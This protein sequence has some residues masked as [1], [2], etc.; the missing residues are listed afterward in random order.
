MQPRD[1]DGWVLPL[2]TSPINNVVHTTTNH[3]LICRHHNNGSCHKQIS[4]PIRILVRNIGDMTASC[5]RRRH[6]SPIPSKQV[7]FTNTRVGADTEFCVRNSRQADLPVTV[8]TKVL[9][10]RQI[11]P[12]CI[13]DRYSLWPWMAGPPQKPAAI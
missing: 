2:S 11:I 3:H 13:S 1:S 6:I 12:Q 10:L 5:W 4:P 7:L 9:V 8:C